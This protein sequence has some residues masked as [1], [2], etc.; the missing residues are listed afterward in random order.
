MFSSTVA[1][2]ALLSAANLLVGLILIRGTADVQ[3]GYYVLIFN[4]ILL[5][6]SLQGAFISPPLAMRLA[7]ATPQQAASLVGGIFRAQNRVLG[8]ALVVVLVLLGGA[9]LAK[10]IENELALLLLV[11]LLS[12]TAALLREFFRM[13]FF[14]NRQPMVVIKSDAVFVAGQ[15]AGVWFAKKTAMPV[16]LALLAFSVAAFVASAML[17]RALK[18]RDGLDPTASPSVWREL[19]GTGIWATAG[20]GSHWAFSQGYNYVVAGVLDVAAVSA[21][22]ATRLL[23]MPIN[24]LSSGVAPL[25]MPFG[26]EWMHSHGR[27]AVLRR[28]VV[29]ATVLTTLSAIY[30]LILWF[31]QDWIFDHLMH[32]RYP[33][34][35]TLMAIWSATFLIAIFRDQIRVLP[36]VCDRF[37]QLWLATTCSATTS[38]VCGFFALRAWGIVGAPLAVLLGE[39]INCAYLVVLSVSLAREPGEHAA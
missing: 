36:A 34:A 22:A 21:L 33:H 2:Q 13:V 10:L 17:W 5:L 28:S 38:L 11:G 37:R 32:K 27:A 39:F 1:N 30:L 14:V 7:K 15:L 19:A 4:S 6:N 18:R 25:L 26:L 29:I 23:M 35:Q 8:V 20:A 16:V 24:L 3:Y 9:W 12:I 31:L